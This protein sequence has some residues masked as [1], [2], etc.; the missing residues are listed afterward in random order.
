MSRIG[1]RRGFGRVAVGTQVD[2]PATG[3]AFAHAGA[4]RVAPVHRR[5]VRL[6]VDVVVGAEVNA[7]PV[8]PDVI[9]VAHRHHDLVLLGAGAL[10][11]ADD[12]LNL[13]AE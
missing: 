5:R 11:E 6:Q 12:V 4:E 9:D 13:A 10:E 1:A 2:A 8:L 7:S 3:R